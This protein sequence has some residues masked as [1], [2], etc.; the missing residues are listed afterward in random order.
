MKNVKY[1]AAG[2]GIIRTLLP[3]DME[4][5]NVAMPKD[6]QLDGQ[7]NVSWNEANH[8]SIVMTNAA[9]DSLVGQLPRE[10]EAIDSDEDDEPIEV[11]EPLTDSIS[12]AQAQSD[13][14]SPE[15]S[16]NADATSSTG[17]TRRKP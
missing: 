4:R 10:F 1:R 9:S 2:S 7:G 15:E 5:L 8:F 13:P 17:T 16:A 12:A 11:V 14:K 6:D 3:S